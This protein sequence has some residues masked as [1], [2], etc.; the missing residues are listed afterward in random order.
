MQIL[1]RRPYLVVDGA[2]NPDSI[3]KLRQTL[4]QYFEFDRTV[5]IVGMSADKEI[6]GIVGAL[7]PT[8]DKVIVTHSQHPRAAT[9]A[10]IVAEFARHG[11]TV[12]IADDTTTALSLA[13]EQAGKRDLICAT[14]SLFI[15]AEVIAQADRIFP[16]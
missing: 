6:T 1:H 16:D 4:K 2:H 13:K 3:L 12:T 10:P 11:I 14:G 15:V 7:L 9:A 8:A 5:L